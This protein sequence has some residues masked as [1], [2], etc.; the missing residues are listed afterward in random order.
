MPCGL[1]SLIGDLLTNGD[2]S[3]PVTGRRAE[4]LT[5]AR[6]TVRGEEFNFDDLLVVAIDRRSPAGTRFPCGTRGRLTLPINP[7]TPGVEPSAQLG[8]PVIIHPR[9]SK[10]AYAIVT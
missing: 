3:P 9:W 10:Q 6:T 7:E 5:R 2:F 4:W 1:E 8:L